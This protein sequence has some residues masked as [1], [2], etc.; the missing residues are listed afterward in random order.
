MQGVRD[1]LK[2]IKRGYTRPSH[3]TSIDV[4]N[5]R[6]KRVEGVKI[7]DEYEG[8]RPPSLDIFLEY[9]GLE[10]KEFIEIAMSHEVSPHK[11]DQQAIQEGEKTHDFNEW[12]RK[13]GLSRKESLNQV[14]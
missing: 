11:H 1:Y 12:N 13:E 5:K 8:K 4:R 2:Y 9:I 6:M 14:K 10:E 3:L 7:I